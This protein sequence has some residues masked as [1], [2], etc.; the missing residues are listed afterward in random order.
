MKLTPL[1]I[2]FILMIL[3]LGISLLGGSV[4]WST[5]GLADDLTI[6]GNAP[7]VRNDVGNMGSGWT[8][9]GGDKGGNRY[10]AASQINTANVNKLAIAWTHH[11]GALDGKSDEARSS[12]ALQTTPILVEDSLVFCT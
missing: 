2:V 9:Y 6:D 8:E 1:R 4:V 12:S 10:V 7:V 11:S 5:L 3:F